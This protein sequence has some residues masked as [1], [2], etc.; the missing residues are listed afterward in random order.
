M[1]TQRGGSWLGVGGGESP[2]FVGTE[3]YIPPE[4]LARRC[5]LYAASIVLYEATTAFPPRALSECRR[6]VCEHR[7]AI[8]RS[9][10]NEII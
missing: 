5:D 8:M 1:T 3:G 4:G 10:C 6:M 9:N 2:T 7:P